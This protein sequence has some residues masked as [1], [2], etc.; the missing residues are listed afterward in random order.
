MAEERDERWVYVALGVIVAGYLIYS[1]WDTIASHTSIPKFSRSLGSI[2]Y[3]VGPLF[4]A[5]MGIARRRK[6]AAARKRWDV[7][8]RT[9]G[10]L[11]DERGV[12]AKIVN[13]KSGGAFQADVRLTRTALYIHDASGR[14]GSMRL[15]VHLESVNDLGLFDVEHTP[16]AKGGRG[17]VTVRIVGRATMAIAFTSAQSLAWWTDIRRVLGLNTD[18]R[19]QSDKGAGGSAGGRRDSHDSIVPT[20]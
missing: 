18:V 10:V 7:T 8:A 15:M 5:V 14:K 20:G 11:R 3:I 6:A 12:R 4:A 13:G 19:A 16:T 17:T 1:N 9:E 2:A